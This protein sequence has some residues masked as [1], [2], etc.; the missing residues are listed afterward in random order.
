MDYK[1]EKRTFPSY[2]IMSI[3]AVVPF[4]QIS[5]A[6]GGMFEELCTYCQKKGCQV[7]GD[8]VALYHAEGAS[9]EALDIECCLPVA[10]LVEEAG[11]VKGRA[12]DG[13]TNLMAQHTHKGP[14]EGLKKVYED[15]MAWADGEGYKWLTDYPM[16]EIYLNDPMTT[17]PEDYLTEIVWPVW[18]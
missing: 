4:S 16:R 8:P 2:K 12:L 18:K 1:V 11:R 3:R 9:M 17:K 7:A 6:M 10:E 13:E 14:Y 15:M 5:G